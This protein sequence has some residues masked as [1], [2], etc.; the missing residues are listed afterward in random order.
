MPASEPKT[1]GR[2]KVE[3]L[4]GAGGMGAVYLAEDPILKRRLAV[5]VVQGG[6]AQ[7]DVLLRFRR[8]AEVSARLN[9]PNVITIYDVG[10]D[11][12]VGP[13]IAMEFVDGASLADLVRAGSFHGPE[14]RLRSL[15][16][17]ALALEAAHAEGIVHRD[18]KP[19]NVMV[20]RDGR[21]KL[22]DFGVARAEDAATITATDSVIGTPAYLAP[23][24]LRGAEPSA[25][26]DRYAFSVMTF[27]VFTGTKPYVAP[28]TSTLLYNIAHEPPVFPEG[29]APALKNVF[30][31]GLAKEPAAR[32]PDLR[33][34]LS[35]M[36]ESSVTDPTVR[37]RLLDGLPSAESRRSEAEQTLALGSSGAGEISEGMSGRTM[38][39]LGATGIAALGAVGLGFYVLGLGSTRELPHALREAPPGAESPLADRAT[40][41]PGAPPT[42]LPISTKPV[43]LTATSPEPA[44]STPPPASGTPQEPPMASVALLAPAAVP[45]AEPR[46]LTGAE[47]RE[48][49]RSALRDQGMRHVDVRVDGEHHLL[50]A[51][52]KDASEAE[53]ARAV[54]TQATSE[55]LQIET[56]LRKTGGDPAAS[57]K[58]SP[59][60]SALEDRPPQAP[61][62]PHAPAWQIHREGSEKID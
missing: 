2:Y 3:H 29:I 38:L 33:S 30:E 11:P 1:I 39:G 23:E 16:A 44:P 60:V 56:S 52:L 41:M 15:I 40:A 5:K 24:Q 47:I 42:D 53:R 59:A 58:R 20:G 46:S 50:L 17:A 4:L 37:A 26:T 35:T 14:D 61:N 51:N 54:A 25:S 32:F 7:K 48:A 28:S 49:V 27:E 55:A 18:I 45:S 12:S 6:M 9:H 31:R 10:E 13:F 57:K 36:I 34:F 21:V 43:L 8:E 19:G 62:A 22:M